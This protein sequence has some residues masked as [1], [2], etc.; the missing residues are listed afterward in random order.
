MRRLVALVAIA[1]AFGCA[2]TPVLPRVDA[3]LG[4]DGRS[5]VAAKQL[6]PS[7][8]KAEWRVAPTEQG[9]AVELRF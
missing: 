8:P 9:A 5:S 3:G 2:G 6:L 4:L 7:E 1:G